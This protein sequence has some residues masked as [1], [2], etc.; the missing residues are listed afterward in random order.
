MRYITNQ[1]ITSVHDE[2]ICFYDFQI[3]GSINRNI[4]HDNSVI[5]FV[6]LFPIFVDFLGQVKDNQG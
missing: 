2:L 6:I 3:S 4:S 1:K 5:I